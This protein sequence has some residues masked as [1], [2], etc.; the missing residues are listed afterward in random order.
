MFVV[1]DGESLIEQASE[2]ITVSPTEW[3][4]FATERFLEGFEQL[5]CQVEET[6]NTPGD[7]RP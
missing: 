1:D 5:R 7:A 3:P 2:P 6:G 4:T